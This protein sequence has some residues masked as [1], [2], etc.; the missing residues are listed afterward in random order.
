MKP[1]A[2]ALL[3]ISVATVAGCGGQRAAEI[4]RHATVSSGSGARPCEALQAIL[5]DART[6]IPPTINAD[7]DGDKRVD[8]VFIAT[9]RPFR[10]SCPYYLIVREASGRT[11]TTRLPRGTFEPSLR[12]PIY[13]GGKRQTFLPVILNHGAATVFPALAEV[14]GRQIRLAR[15]SLGG[16]GARAFEFSEGTGGGSSVIDCIAEP[17]AD[18]VQTYASSTQ[19]GTAWDVE[20]VM[21]K[22]TDHAAFAIVSR[23]RFRSSSLATLPEYETA[24]NLE[25]FVDCR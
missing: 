25:P 24:S 7:L 3:L 23:Q 15:T 14:Q 13:I 18:L 5:N 6:R 11:V 2:I 10:A 21:L 1:P 12:P 16:N 22:L 19:A 4:S 20:R 9:A 17:N 8:T